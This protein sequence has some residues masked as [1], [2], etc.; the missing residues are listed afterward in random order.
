MPKVRRVLETAIY[1]DD[2]AR[3]VEF[4]KTLLALEPM[5]A[6]E[7]VVSVVTARERFQVLGC[8]DPWVQ[9][10][11]LTSFCV[12]S[13]EPTSNPGTRTAEPEPRTRNQHLQNRHEPQHLE[14]LQL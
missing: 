1:C 4:Y 12:R 6:S 13:N 9:V 2:L 5:S 3:T 10:L 11:G 14:P 7:R 8:W